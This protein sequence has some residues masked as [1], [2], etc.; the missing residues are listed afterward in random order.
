[1]HA[2]IAATAGSSFMSFDPVLRRQAVAEGVAVLPA[3]L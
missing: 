2:A 1:V 3:R